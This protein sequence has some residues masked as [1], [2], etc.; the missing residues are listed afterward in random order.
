MFLVEG[1]HW[2]QQPN[3]QQKLYNQAHHLSASHQ[4]QG[5]PSSAGKPAHYLALL[6]RCMPA[7]SSL[8][9][10]DLQTQ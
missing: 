9:Q 6:C 3:L 8:L 10:H 7:K 5:Q 2:H 1:N 4:H